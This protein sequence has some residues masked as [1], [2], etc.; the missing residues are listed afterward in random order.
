[1]HQIY[2]R[3][4]DIRSFPYLRA[5]TAIKNHGKEIKCINDIKDIKGLTKAMGD[6]IKELL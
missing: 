4:G 5:V 6:K 2:K 3:H 1:M